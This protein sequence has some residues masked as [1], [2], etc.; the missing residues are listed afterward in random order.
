MLEQR[1]LYS[2]LSCSGYVTIL[3]PTG[4]RDSTMRIDRACNVFHGI[5]VIVP[6]DVVAIQFLRKSTGLEKRSLESAMGA[7]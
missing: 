7:T 5:P 2:L 3:M 4:L 1:F 6:N